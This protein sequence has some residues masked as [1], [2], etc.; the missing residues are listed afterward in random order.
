MTTAFDPIDLAGMRL[1]NRI[2]MAPMTR[3]RAYGPGQTPTPLMAT[4]YAQ[5]AT[6]GLII[7]EGTQ[8]SVIGQGYPNT[9]GLHSTEQVRGWQQVTDAV[10][11]E[12]GVIFAQLMHTGRIGHPSLLPE[13]LTPVGPSPVAAAGQ[14]FTPEGMKDF[15]TPI[16]LDD[17]G[18]SETINDFAHAARN[19]ITA[20]FDG[21]E[22]HG[23]NGYLL[24][25]FLSTNAN[26]RDDRWGGSIEGRIRLTVEVARAVAEA[27]G[28]HR[29][30][31]RIS[32]TNPLNDIVED[33]YRDTYQALVDALTP[34]G[35]AYLHVMEASDRELTVALRKRF[36]GLFILNPATPGSLTN[37]DALELIEDGTADMIAFASLF[38]ANPDLPAR[39]TAGG[40]FN[41]PD[42]ATFYGGDERGYTDYS[43]LSA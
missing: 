27:I 41:D 42:R 2:A 33:G 31:L 32:P 30:G 12:G 39:L 10:H 26:Q 9:P 21:V 14:V 22:L 7:T 34:I 40:P 11:A 13:G 28:A 36:A 18:I 19:A 38:L 25:Q 16:E 20:G 37:L 23:A 1:R 8:P 6:A 24:H 5:R 3:S 29:V 15:G 35:L 4:Y 43:R 17:G